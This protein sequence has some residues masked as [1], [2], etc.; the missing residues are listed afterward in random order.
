MTTTSTSKTAKPGKDAGIDGSVKYVIDILKRIDDGEEVYTD[1]VSSAD[2][3]DFSELAGLS[4]W[5]GKAFSEIANDR[6][7]GPGV[8]NEGEATIILEILKKEI[9]QETF[10]PKYPKNT[11]E[12]EKKPF[13]KEILNDF[14]PKEANG[15]GH[16]WEFQYALGVELEHGRTRGTNVTNNHPLLTGLIVIAHLSEDTLYYSRLWVSEVE[17]EL[18]NVINKTPDDNEEISK[19]A[20]ELNRAKQYLA[21]R[22]VEKTPTDSKIP[23]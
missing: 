19:I 21:K 15:L 12:A 2:V 6:S 22:I 5:A 18:F 8:V 23:A 1:F 16:L 10:E 20:K 3:K 4:T 14:L 11:P 17:G 9:D 7:F 13:D